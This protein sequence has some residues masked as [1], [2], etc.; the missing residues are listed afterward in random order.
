MQARVHVQTPGRERRERQRRR[1]AVRAHRA[2]GCVELAVG[3]LALPLAVEVDAQVLPNARACRQL[4]C[5]RR[6]CQGTAR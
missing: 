5:L 1:A 3:L 4:K 2:D 6:E